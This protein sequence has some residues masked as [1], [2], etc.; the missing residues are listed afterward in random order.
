MRSPLSLPSSAAS[1]SPPSREV[2]CTHQLGQ[3]LYRAYVRAHIHKHIRHKAGGGK[4]TRLVRERVG[5]TPPVCSLGQPSQLIDGCLVGYTPHRDS[6]SMRGRQ[7]GWGDTH[8]PVVNITQGNIHKA[9]SHVYIDLGLGQKRETPTGQGC[10]WLESTNR[11]GQ[12]AGCVRLPPS[13]RHGRQRPAG[14]Q[15]WPEGPKHETKAKR[16]SRQTRAYSDTANNR[17]LS[18]RNGKWPH[19][20]I[21]KRHVTRRLYLYTK[22]PSTHTTTTQKHKPYLER[23]APK[24]EEH[25][26]HEGRVFSGNVVNDDLAREGSKLLS[27]GS[28]SEKTETTGTQCARRRAAEKA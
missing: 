10:V 3:Y 22:A 6:T 7:P 27:K 24:N 18:T 19:G 12:P 1:A 20:F 8:T 11:P 26:V 25:V 16:G 17:T 14:L 21:E 2:P 15:Q 13:P 9:A 23:R 5:D 28:H 4:A